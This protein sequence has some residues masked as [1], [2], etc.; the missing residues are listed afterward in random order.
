[1]SDHVLQRIPAGAAREGF[2][3]LLLLA[4]ESEIQVRGYLQRGDLYVFSES[5][6]PDEAAGIV[7]TL[8]D[9]PGVVEL[10][11]VAVE[12]RLHR[13]GI[14]MRMVSAVLDDLRA[15]GVE[16]AIVGTGNAGIGQLAFYQKAGF[17][18]LRIERDFFTPARG[19]PE[20]MEENGIR[21]LDMVW[22]D[23]AL[24]PG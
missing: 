12:P 23:C 4:D 16:R 13:Q 20:R 17:R 15:R 1:M 9:E 14:G 11:A 22:M 21:L 7:L 5:E 6:R 2:M 24:T 19:Y 8:P 18:L 10:K 3:P